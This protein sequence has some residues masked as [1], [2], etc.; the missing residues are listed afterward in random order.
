[1]ER[2]KINLYTL[3]ISQVISLTSFGFGLPFIP[4]FIQELGVTDPE[5][6]KIFTGILSAAPAITMAIMSPMKIMDY[7]LFL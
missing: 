4:F 6:L 2:W 3:W 7:F 1:M 5:Q